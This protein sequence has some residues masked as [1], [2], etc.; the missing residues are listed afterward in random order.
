M[1]LFKRKQKK[2]KIQGD[3]IVR[4][5][6]HNGACLATDRITVDGREVG[7]M[8]REITDRNE[9]TGWRFFSGDEDQSYMANNS[10]HGVYAVNTIS[11]HSPEILEYL[12]TP[13]PCAFERIEGSKSF[14]RIE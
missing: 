6:D 5:V 11:N 1:G 4:L 2:L 3:E 7:Y 14:R 10:N 12:N 9:D 13:A 8:Y